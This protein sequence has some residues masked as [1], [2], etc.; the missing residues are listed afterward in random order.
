[1]RTIVTLFLF[2]GL[3]LKAQDMQSCP[4]HKDHTQAQHQADVEKLG[5]EAMG[6]PH[7]ATDQTGLLY[8]VE[9]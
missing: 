8:Q 4:K 5:D 9:C 3:Q 2:C 1:M 7:D 6:F